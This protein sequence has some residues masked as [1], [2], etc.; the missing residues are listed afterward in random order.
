ML[1]AES[2][3]PAWSRAFLPPMMK[4]LLSAA[5]GLLLLGFAAQADSTG[6]LVVTPQST[7]WSVKYQ[8][9]DTS[10]SYTLVPPSGTSADFVITRWPAAGNGDSIPG[11]LDSLAKGFVEKAQ[12]SSKIALASLDYKPGEFISDPFSGQY[13]EFTFKSGVKDYLFMLGDGS[14]LWYG[15]FIG[16]PQGWLNAVEVLKGIKKS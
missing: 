11:Y 14:G 15:H 4:S 2:P 9:T 1:A 5:A 10:E 8:K 13:V 16:T 12:R 3:Q 6:P 7:D